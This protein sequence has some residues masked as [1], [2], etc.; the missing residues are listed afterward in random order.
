MSE[1][2]IGSPWKIAKN[3]TSEYALYDDL[4][5]GDN[6]KLQLRPENDSG[7]TIG[8]FRYVFKIYNDRPAIVFRNPIRSNDARPS[9]QDNRPQQQYRREQPHV[10]LSTQHIEWIRQAAIDS[11]QTLE[12]VRRIEKF[13]TGST[14]TT[15]KQDDN[16]E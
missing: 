13:L 4:P 1:D 6:V 8:D 9:Q 3:G 5:E 16:R 15:S 10:V 12:S 14:S 11:R 7:V 2:N